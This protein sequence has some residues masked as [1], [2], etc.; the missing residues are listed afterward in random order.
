M[1][2]VGG[3][4]ETAPLDTAAAWMAAAS[5]TPNAMSRTPSPCLVTWAGRESPYSTAPS[6][7]RADEN[8]HTILPDPTT[9]V[10]TERDPV[11]SPAYARG[12]NPRREM[13][14][15][16]DCFALPTHHVT[17]SNPVMLPYVGLAPRSV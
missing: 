1:S 13:A 5:V 14:Q 2:V 4:T 10:T 3:R 12:V 8:A 9:W 11:S 17:W 15:V 7:V 6:G 16:A